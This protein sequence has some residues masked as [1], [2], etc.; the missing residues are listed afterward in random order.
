MIGVTEDIHTLD[1]A[2][3]LGRQ[4][5]LNRLMKKLLFAVWASAIAYLFYLLVRSVEAAR[6][7]LDDRV[8]ER[9]AEL[10]EANLRLRQSMAEHKQ[11]E[12]ALRESER[13]FFQIAEHLDEAIS[14]T[15]PGENRTLYISPAA[16]KIWGR[17]C[18]SLQ[19]APRSWR[20]GIHQEDRDR[21][22]RAFEKAQGDL[23]KHAEEYRV[24]RPDGSVRWVYDK[25][26]PFADP[27]GGPSRLV[28]ITTDVTERRRAEEQS[29]ELQDQ[30][31]HMNRLASMGEMASALAHEVNQPLG[32]LANLTSACRRELEAE[33]IGV[34]GVLETLMQI[35]QEIDRASTIIRRLR[36]FVSKE[37]PHLSTVDMDELVVDV[38][39]LL[40]ADARQRNITFDSQL[41]RDLPLLQLDR[42]Q[43]QQVLVNLLRNAFE[44]LE[45]A[46]ECERRVLVRSSLQSSGV[47]VEICNSGPRVPE[48]VLEKMFQPY[49]TTKAKGLGMGLNIS[50]SII[51]HHGGELRVLANPEGGLTVDLTRPLREDRMRNASSSDRLCS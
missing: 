4:G 1:G 18:V 41:A 24:V 47:H 40:G 14:L 29:R 37:P 42:I 21:V 22:F 17:S 45:H 27:H 20:D 50:R 10:D 9:T 44:E 39:R 38:V 49:F 15:V 2:P 11:T 8:K 16:E 48:D 32:A 28:T 43:I 25:W 30:L 23:R 12:Q 34:T 31:A 35:R 36:R 5:P 3:V 19:E 6:R 33:Q 46:G 51:A 7:V 13:R 26:I